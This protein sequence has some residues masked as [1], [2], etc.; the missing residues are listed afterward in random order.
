MPET[1]IKVYKMR[2]HS[3]FET[4]N[5]SQQ[6]STQIIFITSQKATRRKKRYLHNEIENQVKK[7][8]QKK[9]NMKH[10][11]VKYN[12]LLRYAKR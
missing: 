6:Q 2:T 4:V 10:I 11:P 3:I 12:F 8:Q 5:F 1:L 7:N 9:S